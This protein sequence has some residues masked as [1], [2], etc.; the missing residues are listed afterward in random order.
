MAQTEEH[1]GTDSPAHDT[2]TRKGEEMYSSHGE[3]GRHRSGRSGAD[4]P[5]GYSTARSSTGINPDDREPI[6][7]R[8]PHIPPA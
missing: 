8:M 4:R 6:D 5:A 1:E 7:P 3:P 2:G